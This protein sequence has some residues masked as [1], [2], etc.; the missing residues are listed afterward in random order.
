MSDL[1]YP[2]FPRGCCISLAG[3]RVPRLFASN[4]YLVLFASKNKPVQG[5]V[6][7]VV[8]YV[9]ELCAD[10]QLPGAHRRLDGGGL[11]SWWDGRK[12]RDQVV[13]PAREAE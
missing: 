2:A 4:Y 8:G 7:V 3:F 13:V 6:D 1:V 10:C 9:D 11:A 5:G 12:K